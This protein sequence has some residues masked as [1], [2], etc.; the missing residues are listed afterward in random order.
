M[1]RH[2]HTGRKALSGLNSATC[3]IVPIG[4][5]VSAP[6]LEEY[7]LG[8][9]EHPSVGLIWRAMLPQVTTRDFAL[10]W[11]WDAG[12]LACW[13]NRCLIHAGTG[14]DRDRYVREMWRTVI[15]EPIDERSRL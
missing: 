5:P 6:E 2:P 8:G 14:F 11:Q 12:D 4:Q 13:D 15:T 7:E 9:R 10:V 1:L 3:R